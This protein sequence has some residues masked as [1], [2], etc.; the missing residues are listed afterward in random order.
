MSVG[1]R[2]KIQDLRS[3]LLEQENQNDSLCINKK[4]FGR[5][6]LNSQK[7]AGYTLCNW[8]SKFNTD[9]QIIGAMEAPNFSINFMLN[10]QVD[11]NSNDIFTSTMKKNLNNAWSMPEAIKGSA[12][13]RK[14][15]NCQTFGIIFE[16]FYLKTLADKYT[17]LIGDIYKKYRNNDPFVLKNN[18]LET[19]VK[20]NE[21][22]TDIN[23][24]HLMGNLSE[25]YTDS[26]VLELLALQLSNYQNNARKKTIN[27]LQKRNIDIAYEAREIMTRELHSTPSIHNLA[28]QV[29]TN[30]TNL[31]RV[32][33]K[34]I[35]GFLFEHKMNL[36]KSLL[37]DTELS[38]SKAAQKCGYE[39]RSHFSTAFKR[40]F[41]VSPKDFRR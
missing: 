6:R 37:L 22:I 10:G 31:K 35:Y 15:E 25:L 23:Q 38:I 17:D 13:Y 34:T 1:V 40:Y 27:S 12:Q 26:K 20:M 19:S 16:D 30:E 41:G 3:I 14:N 11:Y 29:G 4:E 33:N 5:I 21:V 24:A 7:A 9:V 39:Y 32:F 2:I 28:L 36:A 18:H 8:E